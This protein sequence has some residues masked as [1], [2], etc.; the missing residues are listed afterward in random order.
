MWICEYYT[1]YLPYILPTL[2]WPKENLLQVLFQPR[3]SHPIIV[4]QQK[5]NQVKEPTFVID[6]DE[7]GRGIAI[8]QFPFPLQSL[9]IP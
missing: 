5:D 9:S 8:G 7:G 4:V 6:E 2:V 1:D 3:M